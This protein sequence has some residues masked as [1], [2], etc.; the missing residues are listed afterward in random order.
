MADGKYIF[1]KEVLIVS[2]LI[3]KCFEH[4]VIA[5]DQWLCLKILSFENPQ[6]NIAKVLPSYSYAKR[7]SK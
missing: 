4:Y 2:C 6:Q 5:C 7:Q 1:S 3:M